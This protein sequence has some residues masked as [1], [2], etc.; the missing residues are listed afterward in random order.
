MV[1][2]KRHER[3]NA[4]GPSRYAHFLTKATTICKQWAI[5]EII[6][7]KYLNKYTLHHTESVL[8]VTLMVFQVSGLPRFYGSG[9]FITVFSMSCPLLEHILTSSIRPWHH[10]FRIW[11]PLILPS[12]AVQI[13]QLLI[14]HIFTHPTNCPWE[15]GMPWWRGS[16]FT[17]V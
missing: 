9:R 17:W 15:C 1:T 7:A 5:Y 2:T 10:S 11:N 8:L 6:T 4:W 14:Q 3:L 16:H 13:V 12:S